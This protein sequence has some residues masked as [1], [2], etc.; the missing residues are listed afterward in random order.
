[1]RD[2]KAEILRRLAPLNLAPT[3]EADIAD[4]LS[5]HLEDRYQE[6]LASGQPEDAAFRTALDELKGEDLLAR[7]LKRIERNF[8]REPIV[9]GKATGNVFEGVVQDVRHAVRMLAKSPGFS[10]IAV[11]TLALGIGVNTAMFSLVDSALFKPLYAANPGQLVSIFW[12]DKGGNGLSN[13]SYA[14]YLDYRRESASVMSG[15]AAFTTTPGT[16]LLGQTTERINVG[17]VTENYFSVLGVSPIAGRG[18]LPEENRTAGAAFVAV[19]GEGLWRKQ[20]GS[21][22]DLSGKTVLLNNSRYSVVGVFPERAC[23]MAG[24]VKIDVFVLAVMEGVIS[25][26]KNF[27]STRDNKEFMVV[28]R[29]RNGVTVSRAQAQ[30]ALIAEEL[31]K[32]YPT[33]WS[34]NGRPHEL[35]VVPASTVPFELRGMVTGF[36]GLLLA[37][38]IVV[39]L[40]VCANLGGFL[41]ARL[42]A[43]RKE[44][45]VRV[46][47]G[48]SRWRLVQQLLTENSLV[49]LLGGTAG[50]LIALWAKSLLA[51]F[52]PNIGVPLIIDLTVD[53]RVLGFSALLTVLTA[54]A[55]GLGPALQATK[56]D[57]Q[58]GLKTG[59]QAQTGALGRTRLRNALL[60]GQVALSLV[61]LM[62]AGIFFG[63]FGKLNS[64][65]LGFDPNNLA[66]LSADLGAEENSGGKAQE[67][68]RQ[69][70]TRLRSVPGAESVA[71]AADVPMGLSRVSEQVAPDAQAQSPMWI[72]SN[73]VGPDYF[74]VMRIPLLGGRPFTEQDNDHRSVT[75]VNDTLANLLWPHEEALG[76]EI[77]ETSGKT[78]EVV[79]VVKTGK[80]HSMDENPLPY[81][82]F[83][84][85]PSSA[86]V[87]TFQVRTA[88]PAERMLGLLRNKLSTVNPSI[89]VFDVETMNEHLAD[90]MLPVRMGLILLG[91]FGTLALALAS[92]GLYGLLSYT[93]RQRTR[94]IGIRMA[95][96]ASPR[97]VLKTV[98][99]RG[100][101]LTIVGVAIG[102]VVGFAISI[103]IGSQLYG[104][105]SVDIAAL[106]GVVLLQIGVA[107]VACYVPAR[108]SMHVDPMVALRYE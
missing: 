1:M 21:S 49:V 13:H 46:A 17:L 52:A 50:F 25:G 86:R 81:A 93:V 54:F 102:A 10:A 68:I 51:A 34:E 87:L 23:R 5:Q 105:A 101:R 83:L 27:L 64:V 8:Y 59:E 84:L 73:M 78:Y 92:I 70:L 36:A 15:L 42:L 18:F 7:G 77:R 85:N 40:A 55:L 9:P 35:S 56:E 20:Y 57:V 108:R 96:G 90:S 95:L 4:E 45:A 103:L 94:E 48:A 107:L 2:W 97:Q 67:F 71:I 43:R 16:L 29:L 104:I 72:G 99:G 61:L 100:V 80:Y 75:I 82:Y 12:G 3:R 19:I 69:S 32:Q 30:F 22:A 11:L 53:Y 63:S 98:I 62:C 65:D 37:A 106:V 89:P 66:L 31:H 26:D 14:D 74:Q 38:A 44:I 47:L 88:I 60:I 91:S 6:L 58:S 33:S 39:L 24:V 76:K 28:G 41:V 79:G